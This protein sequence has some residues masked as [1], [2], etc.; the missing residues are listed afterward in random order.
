VLTQT[1]KKLLTK[2]AHKA[3]KRRREVN[4]EKQCSL[5]WDKKLESLLNEVK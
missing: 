1:K 4:H 2:T 3:E 5:E